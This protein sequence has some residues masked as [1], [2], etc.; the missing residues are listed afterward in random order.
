MMSTATAT[1]LERP[2]PASSKAE[3]PSVYLGGFSRQAL[4][5]RED[6]AELARAVE[7]G[8]RAILQAFVGSKIALRELAEIGAELATHRLRLRDVL[9]AADDEEL[10]DEEALPRLAALLR[11]AGALARALE[12]GA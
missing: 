7:A 1:L 2:F 5:T 8:E 3:A 9:R 6:E 12:Q 10:A 4:L 11:R